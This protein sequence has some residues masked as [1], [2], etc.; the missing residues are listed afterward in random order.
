MNSIPYIHTF[1]YQ[2]R[3][4]KMDVDEILLELDPKYAV[5]PECDKYFLTQEIKDIMSVLCMSSEEAICFTC[6]WN[7]KHS[8]Y[9]L[10]KYHFTLKDVER[11]YGDKYTITYDEKNGYTFIKKEEANDQE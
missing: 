2:E 8:Y 7:A 4:R 11:S 3:K 5:C 9:V 10:T 6:G 1:K